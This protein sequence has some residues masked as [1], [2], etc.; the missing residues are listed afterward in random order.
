MLNVLKDVLSTYLLVAADVNAK[1][2]VTYVD[3]EISAIPVP[4]GSTLYLYNNV[5]GTL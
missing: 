3:G 4:T 1:A 2:D 5:G